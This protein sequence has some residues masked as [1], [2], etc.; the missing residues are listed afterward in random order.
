MLIW[1]LV[2]LVTL[3]FEQMKKV[4]VKLVMMCAT[5]FVPA[6]CAM[7]KSAAPS[8]GWT[9][10]A[11]DYEGEYT[12]IPVANGRIGILPWR[13]PGDVRHVMLNHVFD[14]PAEGK[15][16]RAL[17]GINPLK[18]NFYVDGSKI[19]DK[20]ISGWSQTLDMRHA[21]HT[22]SF[23][24]DN[25][26][27]VTYTITALRNMPYSA[28]IEV[29]MQAL[30]PCSVKIESSVDIPDDYKDSKT[31]LK[32]INADRKDHPILHTDAISFSGRHRSSSAALWI[33]ESGVRAQEPAV[34]FN[35]RKGDEASATLAASFCTSRDFIDPL[36]EVDRQV[37]YIAERTPER[38]IEDHDR[39]WDKL[40]EGDVII[41]GD[42]EAQ[43]AVR[44]ALYSL[45]SFC[46][47][48]SGL[49]I[50]PMGLSSQGYNGHIFW[51]SEIWMYPPMLFVNP[52][53]ARSMID[54]RC[55]RLDAARTRASVWGYEGAMFPWES[56]D[57]GQESCPTWALTG[58]MEHHITPDI[59][60]AAWNYYRATGDKEWIAA[61]G[62]PLIRDIADF[63]VSRVE[64][65]PDG[66]LTVRNVV[67]ADEYA[68]GVDDNAFTN[69]AM[70]CALRDAMKAASVL[71][72]IA[73]KEWG[74]T[75]DAIP[76]HKNS[77][78][79][80]LE[81]KTYNG[82]MIKQADVNLLAYPLGL[83][84]DKAQIERDLNYYT[85]KIDTVNGPAMAYGVMAVSLARV[86]RTEEALAMFKRA[87]EP[88][89]RKP[90]GT[91]AETA[92][93]QNPYFATG[94]GAL[95][96]GAING[97]CGL[98]LTDSGIVQIPV[99]LPESWNSVTVTG[100]GP[101]KKTFVNSMH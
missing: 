2:V 1:G 95:L 48:G 58:T 6:F 93:A 92:T 54:Y 84:T 75:A 66:K 39:L 47:K 46:R 98:E 63:C 86:G 96:Q 71:G 94:A 22:T 53:I 38:L 45:Y 32:N 23:V 36:N 80:T 83:I 28:L 31:Q 8:E 18:L 87:Y 88:N 69:G 76:I 30:S 25:K 91:L 82:E 12:G 50:S 34:N 74:E 15:V 70:I 49:S 65:G 29:E 81:H 14:F 60:I 19:S 44:L 13:Q 101:E 51:D 11:E 43:Q 90:F 4:G 55:D 16:N 72:K 35:L 99:K 73:P 26:V 89:V 17:R 52:D 40:W 27:H 67:G 21:H 42:S 59:A 62:W 57:Y 7:G 10:T 41:D 9:I 97:W 64:K 79:V 68:I 61:K 3:N 24:A 56:D 78:G 85:S 37:I 100:V 5:A 20:E 77:D 33:S